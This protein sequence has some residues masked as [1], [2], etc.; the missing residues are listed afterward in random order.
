MQTCAGMH[1]LHVSTNRDQ[2][3]QHAVSALHPVSNPARQAYPAEAHP[4]LLPLPNATGAAA[5][6]WLLPF[7]LSG[8]G[9]GGE[10]GAPKRSLKRKDCGTVAGLACTYWLGISCW[11]IQASSA[12]VTP[13]PQANHKYM[14]EHP[15]QARQGSAPASLTWSMIAAPPAPPS[16]LALVWRKHGAKGRHLARL[17]PVLPPLLFLGTLLGSLHSGG[18][19]QERWQSC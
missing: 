8:A 1:S 7:S 12:L 6:D 18:G 15:F 19:S 17:E 16:C 10:S 9:A 4:L 13:A 14:T 3:P 2:Q 5:A 11:L